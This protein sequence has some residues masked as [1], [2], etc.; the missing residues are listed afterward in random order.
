MNNTL[1]DVTPMV[2][3]LKADVCA[4]LGASATV[5]FEICLSE[6]LTN[7]VKHAQPTT[8]DELID[9]TVQETSDAIC[10]EIY[11]PAGAAP[12]DFRDHALDLVTVDPLAESGRGLGLIMQCADALDYGPSGDRNR[13]ILTFNK[14]TQ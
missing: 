7:V 4:A 10:V 2:L 5:R 1:E 13:L 6:A 9:V 12:F 3:S 14:V 11:D 8:P